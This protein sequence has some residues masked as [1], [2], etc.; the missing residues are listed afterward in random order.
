MTKLNSGMI[1]WD[2]GSMKVGLCKL[3]LK[4]KLI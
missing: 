4:L 1:Q 3:N 2:K